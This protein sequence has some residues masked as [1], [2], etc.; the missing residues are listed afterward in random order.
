PD[1]RYLA[2]EARRAGAHVMV[3]HNLTVQFTPGMETLPI[4]FREN[5]MEVIASLPY[6]LAQQT[7][8]QRGRGVFDQS[9]LA[10]RRLNEEG[11]GREGTGLSLHLVYNP[12][13][14]FLP[15]D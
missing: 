10:L 13:G 6:F 2:V 8:A 5:E 11:Y 14:A 3:R 4:F 7:D 9:L 1:F 12:V 15:P